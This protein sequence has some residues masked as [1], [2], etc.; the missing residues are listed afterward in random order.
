MLI[1]SPSVKT[2]ANISKI[3]CSDKIK[4]NY[5]T[6]SFYLWAGSK[7]ILK[8][9]FQKPHFTVAAYQSRLFRPTFNGHPHQVRMTA[10]TLE[11]RMTHKG[12]V[13]AWRLKHHPKLNIARKAYQ[14]FRDNTTN[15]ELLYLYSREFK[16]SFSFTSRKKSF[17]P[18]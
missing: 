3:N 17:V 11:D 12:R 5:F 6:E 2:T 13:S 10:T 7:I 1:C 16:G 18:F 4:I 15:V 9:D 14:A 8:A